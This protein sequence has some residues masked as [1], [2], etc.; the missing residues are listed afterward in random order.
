M[1]RP[2]SSLRGVGRTTERKLHG[3]GIDTV[4][5]L[6]LHLPFRHEPPSRI[7][8][9]GAVCSGEEATLRVRIQSC[10]LRET[11]RRRVKVLEALVSDD[12]GSVIAIWYNQPYLEAAFR[13]RPEVLLKGVLMRRRGASTFLVKRHEIL[14]E[15]QESVHILGLVPVYPSTADLSVR[16]IRTVLHSA[17]REA[18][19]IVDPLP[20]EM[21][22]RRRYPAKPDAVLSSHFPASLWEAGK[23]RERLAFE[24]LL[25]L[26][27]AVLEKRQS[28]GARRRARALASPATLAGTFL[29]GLSYT[30]TDAQYRVIA[31][32][33]QD[34]GRD[35]PMRRLLHGDVGSGK[36]MVAAYCLLRA[37]E[38]GAQAALM[39]PTEVLADQ[40]FLG[41]SE[42]LGRQEVRVRLL[43]GSQP[44]RERRAIRGA[45][46]AGE[47]DVVIGTHALIQE[48]VRFHDLRLA[49][50]DEQH[51]FGVRQRDAIVA[52]DEAEGLWPHTLHMS[53]TPIP[54][55]LGLTLY[56]DLD[57]SVLDEMPPG[58]RPVRTRLVFAD[59]RPRM[60]AFVRSELAKGRQ[61]YVVCPLI[62]ESEVLQTAS[63][64]RAYEELAAGD[65]NG[66][67][68]RLLHGQLPSAEKAAAMAAYAA[69]DA[70]VLVSTS[71]IEVGIDVP[72]ATVMVIMGARRFGLSQLHQLRGR[73][74][75]G[76]AESHCFLL[77]EGEDDA[78]LERLALFART[79]D[80]FELAE[81]DLLARG[82][83]QLFGERQ[84]G[85]GDLEVASLLRD[86]KLLEEARAEAGTLLREAGTG[87]LSP[88]LR[89]VVEAARARFAQ[90][91]AWM[92]R[93]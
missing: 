66:F 35:V 17:A 53:A 13:E 20:A 88:P 22:A 38:Q 1:T 21:L 80:G 89:E 24:E 18:R 82:E 42:E 37:V 74:G 73:V 11:S 93:A 32:I 39:A 6:L 36:T 52:V 14:T 55:T 72:N 56:G 70:D 40:H 92:E 57:I 10:A 50:V 27:V 47:V 79:N 59:S 44:A 8:C 43:K 63:A 28:Q 48:G 23:A 65:L 46:E 61:A 41:L 85:L 34:L 60:W 33:D 69:G 25:M 5:E 87:V 86:R 45:L 12:T 19:H 51:R 7:A 26:Q 49:V 64:R 9:V 77:A 3:L 68:L 83:G 62:E 71:V 4:G 90:K 29:R 91:I 81:A 2:V 76:A 30:P 84:S 78:V 75:R 16:I 15:A 54:R 67:R 31:E 58:R